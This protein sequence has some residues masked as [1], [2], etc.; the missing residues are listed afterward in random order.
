MPDNTSTD[1][2]QETRDAFNKAAALFNDVLDNGDADDAQ[3][4]AAQ[5]ALEQT[6]IAYG[7]AVLSQLEQ[8]TRFLR[9]LTRAL[10]QIISSIQINPIGDIL[11]RAD[12]LLASVNKIISNSGSSGGQDSA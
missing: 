12:S 5:Q 6:Q 8:R 10:E 2:V 11:D 7:D 4:N 1:P 9:T 3:I